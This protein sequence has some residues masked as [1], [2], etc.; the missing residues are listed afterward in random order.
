MP[1]VLPMI[2]FDGG[3]GQISPLTDLLHAQVALAMSQLVPSSGRFSGL[4]C[5]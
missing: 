3:R 2:L 4:A 5:S 1:T